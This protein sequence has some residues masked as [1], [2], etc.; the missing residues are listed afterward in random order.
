MGR[1]IS[2]AE[3]APIPAR[4]AW[5][6]G[7]DF[8]FTVFD[9]PDYQTRKRG[10]P[11]YRF[12]EDCGFRT[13]KGVFVC[14]GNPESSAEVTCEDPNYLDW[15]LG[16]RE[17]GFEIGWHGAAP[18]SSVRERTLKGLETFRALFGGWPV[19]ASQHFENAESVYWGDERLSTKSHK[20]AYNL[21]TRGK[22][23]GAFHGHVEGHRQFWAD[24]CRERI[25]YMRNFVF[26]SL[27]TLAEC[28]WMPY[29][30]PA[31]PYV[32]RWY[33]STLGHNV[34]SFVRAISERNQDRLEASG[35]AAI[36][37]AHFAYRFCSDGRI[38]PRFRK[39]MER[40]S[41]KNGWFVPVGA[42]LDAIAERRGVVQLND[43]MRR[44]MERRWLAQKLLLGNT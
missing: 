11:V 12:L 26:K 4:I 32:Q 15:V 18:G 20:L 6:E 37:Y 28:P 36:M 9:D 14:A 3:R 44:R 13:T 38:E 35:G 27:D 29:F 22:N 1:S 39:L 7:K 8:A 43:G 31:R 30:D 33:A 41:R 16:L 10:E 2:D 17:R 5:P 34:D 24:L 21:L 40:L 23:R 25:R 42:L 19:A